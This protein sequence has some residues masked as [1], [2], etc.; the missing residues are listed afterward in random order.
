M[1]R[2]LIFLV[3]IAASI[4][5]WQFPSWNAARQQLAIAERRVDDLISKGTNSLSFS[6]LNELR[7]LPPSIKDAKRLVYLTLRDTKISDISGVEN[8]RDLQNLDL[9]HTRVVDLT[10][11]SGLP[12]LQL[13]YLHDTWVEDLTPLASLPSLM[14]LDIGKTQVNSLEPVTRVTQLIWLN[15]YRSYALDGS[16]EHYNDLAARVYELSGGSSYRQGYRPGWKYQM[17][18]R[19]WRFKERLGL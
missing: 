3:I 4:A 18:V 19:Y 10:P 17:M 11:L 5:M 12:K 16:T 6:D 8:L 14:R 1:K 15:L 7:R 13:L 9:N 2:F